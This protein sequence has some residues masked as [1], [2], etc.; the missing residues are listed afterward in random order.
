MVINVLF[1]KDFYP[2]KDL[3]FWQLIGDFF[4]IMSWILAFLMIAKSMSMV[5]ITA[6]V[7]FAILLVLI[8]YYSININGIMGTR[9]TYCINYIL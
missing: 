3:F 9:R 2:M 6:E 5:Y 7:V 4:K 8:S 1:T